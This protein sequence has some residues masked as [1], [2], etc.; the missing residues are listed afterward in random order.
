MAKFC[1][2]LVSRPSK[3][4]I[5]SLGETYMFNGAFK[6]PIVRYSTNHY[7]NKATREES[8]QVLVQTQIEL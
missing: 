5:Y 8:T 1:K 6:A 2:K 3:T 7:C 4:T